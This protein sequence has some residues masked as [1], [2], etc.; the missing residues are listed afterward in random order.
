MFVID[1]VFEGRLQNS[2][3]GSGS[4]FEKGYQVVV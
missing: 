1:P 4:K 3:F 2:R